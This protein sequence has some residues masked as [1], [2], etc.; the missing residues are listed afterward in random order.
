MITALRVDLP[1]GRVWSPAAFDL[2]T[3]VVVFNG[4][5][6]LHL[7][8]EHHALLPAS[9]AY[10]PTGT[11]FRLSA[12]PTFPLTVYLW[13][14]SLLPDR[15]PSRSPL[16]V[17]TLWDETTSFRPKVGENETMAPATM[18]F[19]HWPGTGSPLLCLHCGIQQPGQ[20]FPVHVHLRSEELFI[21]FRGEGDCFLNGKW[22][23]M[24][25][26]DALYAPSGLL[27]GV[28]NAKPDGE[29]FVTCGGPTP[30]DPVL[31][32]LADLSPEVK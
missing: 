2:E 32:R 14:A 31:Y 8:Q 15:R 18:H 19:L 9:T 22:Q 26:G 16:L 28:R 13:R 23:P 20:M 12:V 21:A 1:P 30:F 3:I 7:G 11:P 10:A 4:R 24:V 6:E 17:S 5:G 29:P 25:A 27:H